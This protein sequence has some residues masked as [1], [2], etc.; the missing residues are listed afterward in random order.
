LSARG[1]FP[2]DFSASPHALVVDDDQAISSLLE[3]IFQRQGYAVEVLHDGLKA[4]EHISS[5]HAPPDVVILDIMLPRVDGFAL[6][7]K[8]RLKPSWKEVPVLM[9]SAL[10]DEQTIVRALDAGANDYVQKPFK[11]EEL[12]ARVRRL[13]RE[14]LQ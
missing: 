5:D 7:R 12:K 9:L 10:G 4:D 6:L 8:I 13:I 3:F 11:P 2:L 14:R 1:I